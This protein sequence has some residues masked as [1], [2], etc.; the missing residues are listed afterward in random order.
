MSSQ[1]PNP[2]FV[3]GYQ[4]PQIPQKGG[5]GATW[6]IVVLSVLLVLA[7]AAAGYGVMQR[8]EDG[9]G[10]SDD[11]DSAQ[12]PEPEAATRTVTQTTAGFTIELPETNAWQDESKESSIAPGAQALFVAPDLAAYKADVGAVGFAIVSLDGIDF[13]PDQYAN[14]ALEDNAPDN[15]C[16][17]EG[18]KVFEHEGWT[19]KFVERSEACEWNDGT[20]VHPIDYLQLRIG[21]TGP[22][23]DKVGMVIRYLPGDDTQELALA[24]L[25]SFKRP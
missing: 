19:G 23:G 11:V 1:E 7:I 13:T 21:A 4:Q 16:V 12:T 10:A 14:V 6:A 8:L 18:P 2:Q 3:P 5:K 22:D 15:P 17:N 24:A 25:E 20:T 9:G